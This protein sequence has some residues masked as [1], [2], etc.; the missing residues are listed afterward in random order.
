MVICS[1]AIISLLMHFPHFSK[2]LLGIHAWRQT[3]TQTTIN[4]FYEEDMNILNSR[5]Y[6]RGS[7]EGIQRMEFPLIQWIIALFYKV[8]G[9]HIIITRITM[10]IISLFSV[11]GIYR[12]LNALS[13]NEVLALIGAWAL[14]FSPS[15]YYYTINPLPDNI[16]LCFGVW[17]L[18]YFFIW[19]KNK[20]N[21]LLFISG[22]LLSLATLC[23]LPFVLFYSVPGV[24]LLMVFIWPALK[25]GVKSDVMRGI[26]YL[27]I[28]SCIIVFPVAWYVWVIPQWEGNGVVSG[29]FDN[30][31]SFEVLWAYLTFN[32]TSTLPE[33]LVNYGAVLF[34]LAGFY[35]TIRMK[36]YKKDLFLPL[37]SCCILLVIYYLFEM[38]MIARTHDY[39][40]FPFYPVIMILIS[41]GAYHLLSSENKFFKNLSVLCFFILPVTAYI[42][43][44]NRWNEETPGFNKDL[45]TY[46]TELRAAVP[47][48][49]LC[50]AGNDGSHF[51][52]LYYIHKKGWVYN[53][54][55]LRADSL[56]KMISEGAEYLYSD[57]RDLEKREDIKPFL[58]K[59]VN[60]SGTVRV[61][62]LKK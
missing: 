23:K 14:N 5:K 36:L 13:G 17:G 6:E 46:K 51:I 24:Y 1:I 38:N 55:E 8:L 44:H 54:D 27:L 25:S 62:R 15:F 57:S 18:S 52:F 43:M 3:Q 28:Q 7:G 34:F 33:L 12:L 35:F 16:A 20:K 26:K 4:C 22:M 39:Y 58:A 59:M 49:A 9:S 50:V 19:I 31:E 42:R 11:Y 30:R 40:L 10:F 32:L 41:Y 47:E 37:L 21:S 48:D 45:L 60:E 56:T 61:F 29:V 53:Y 2:D